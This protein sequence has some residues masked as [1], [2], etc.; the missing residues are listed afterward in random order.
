MSTRKARLGIM[1][2][3]QR[4][5]PPFAN[6]HFYRRLCLIGQ[7]HGLIVYVFTTER[8]HWESGTVTGFTVTHPRGG[9]I[10]QR[11]PLP[12]LIYDRCFFAGPKEYLAASAQIRKLRRIKRIAFLGYGLPGKWKVNEM[13]A[14]DD[15]IAPHLPPMARVKKIAVVRDWLDQHDAV[16]LK[17]QG[18]SQGRGTMQ[19]KAHAEGRHRYI[20]SGRDA[21]NRLYR[22]GF[23]DFARLGRWLMRIT[24]ERNYVMQPFLKLATPNHEPY[25]IRSFVQKNKK[26]E[27][28]LIGTALRVGKRGALTSNLHGGGHA[29][30]ALPFLKR[31]YGED[32]AGIM[33]QIRTLTLRIAGTLEQHHGRL[34]E[35]GVDIGIDPSGQIWILEVNSKPGRSVFAR[36]QDIS[37]SRLTLVNPIHYARYLWDRQL[38]G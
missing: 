18:G 2:T 5:Q 4:R 1:V 23:A 9:W 30:E 35:L 27:W 3:E 26:G 8:I 28:Q 37:A 38:G 25:D 11:F 24:S 16:F 14:R 6:Q 19:I 22:Y 34:V 17:P 7:R 15:E 21:R 29:E 31:H 33:D 12:D 32:A 10:K 13:L 36:I 20:V